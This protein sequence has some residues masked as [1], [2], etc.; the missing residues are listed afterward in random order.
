MFLIENSKAKI[1]KSDDGKKATVTFTP[2]LE[3]QKKLM[4]IYAVF[5]MLMFYIIL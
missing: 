2:D 3:E 5:I 4:E 1:E